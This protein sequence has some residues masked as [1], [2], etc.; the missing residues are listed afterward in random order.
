MEFFCI[1]LSKS[2]NWRGELG[3][4]ASMLQNCYFMTVW[5]WNKFFNPSLLVS[6]SL[7]CIYYHTYLAEVLWDGL[8]SLIHYK[9]CSSSDERCPVFII[10]LGVRQFQEFS[11]SFNFH[12]I[13]LRGNSTWGPILITNQFMPA[14]LQWNYAYSIPIQ[15]RSGSAPECLILKSLISISSQ[16]KSTV[17]GVGFVLFSWHGLSF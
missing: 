8:N 11:S 17:L 4:I 9:G 16:C 6:P 3:F 15:V 14:Q 13:N 5:F 12:L 7:K 2:N 1:C 10:G